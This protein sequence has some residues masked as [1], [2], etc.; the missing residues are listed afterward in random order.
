[1]ILRRKNATRHLRKHMANNPIALSE[2]EEFEFRARAEKEAET[3]KTP[4]QMLNPVGEGV[5][6]LTS[7]AVA[8]PVSGIAGLAGA[9]LLGP[10]G[11][12]ADWAKKTQEA[13]TYQPRSEEAQ[14]AVGTITYPFAKLSELSTKGGEYVTDKIGPKTGTVA[15]VIGDML[16]ALA[17]KGGQA[18]ISMAR[19][20]VPLG[21]LAKWTM[22]KAVSPTPT[23]WKS[24]EAAK[25]IDTMLEGGYSP[26]KKGVE[27]MRSRVDDLNDKIKQVLADSDATVDKNAILGPLM[28]RLEKFKENVT[29]NANI[30]TL[31]KAW[32]EFS[33]HPYFKE[34]S[35]E[36]DRLAGLAEGRAA[37]KAKALQEAGKFETF[38]AQQENLAQGGGINLSKNQPVNEPYMNV[39]GDRRALS[40]SAY[41][42]EGQPRVPPRYTENIQR[43]PEGKSAAV[44]A[45]QIY[46]QRKL[47]E[48]VALSELAKFPGKDRIP[49]QKA[50]AMKTGTYK[51]LQSAYSKLNM[52]DSSKQV[53]MDLA[54]G[55]KEQIAKEAPEVDLMNMEESKLLG[56]L[57]VAEHKMYK[58][59]S[60]QV[61]GIAW[62]ASGIA[63]FIAFM[64]D[65]S[66]AFKALAAKKLYS[67][68]QE[69]KSLPTTGDYFKAGA[70]N[71]GL[72]EIGQSQQ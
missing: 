50:Q 7:G 11:Q 54:R 65:R 23:Q 60:K 19:N 52:P 36:G 55:L 57:D 21:E 12:G 26:T 66:T 70:K 22:G 51:E 42:V 39:G 29:P 6:A 16:P 4:K 67:M 18:G 58:D 8:G 63:K 1:M 13:L 31:K 45:K 32:K 43:V 68:A 9:I 28:E 53:R 64:G 5:A 49:I 2:E 59:M 25:A 33:D 40:P 3:R 14:Q 34:V 72:D 24:G 37:S 27:Q 69:K 10:Q 44:E 30:N 15:K 56:A 62:N 46:E 35:K 71:V 17:L 41:P 38:A 61:G 48:K 20:A 47:E